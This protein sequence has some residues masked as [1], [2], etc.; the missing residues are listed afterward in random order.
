MKILLDFLPI[1]VFFAAY[2]LHDLFGV[3]KEEAIYFATPVLM[4]A[5][6]FQ[7]SV[8][9]AIDRKLTKL[10]QVT[11]VAV[12][13]FGG[14]TLALHDKRF[15]MWKPTILYAGIALALAYALWVR[16]NNFLKSML[17]SQLQLPDLVWHNLNVVWVIYSAFM[18]TSN[19]VVALYFSEEAWL[20]FKLWGY[21]FPL[22]FIVGQG[23]YI[24]QYLEPDEVHNADP[25]PKP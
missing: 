21:V 10:H 8:I 1:L 4:A 24:A 15:I 2:K 9:Y 6:V 25:E 23:I 11:L 16:K 5:T 19:G 22:S 18:A 3:G 7:M 20:N 13:V 12:L 17:G 14:V